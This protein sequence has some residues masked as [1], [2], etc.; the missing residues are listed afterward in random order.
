MLPNDALNLRPNYK[1]AIDHWV[2]ECRD[3]TPIKLQCQNIQRALQVFY[4]LKKER[5]VCV[6]AWWGGGADVN[7]ELKVLYN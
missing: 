6:C 4:N 1:C 2:G 5:N 7:Q 3:V